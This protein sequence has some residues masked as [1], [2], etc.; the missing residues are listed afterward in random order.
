MSLKVVKLKKTDYSDLEQFL[1]RLQLVD[2]TNAFPE[3]VY[4]STADIRKFRAA[5]TKQGRKQGLSGR[6]LEFAV[7]AEMLN[8]SP[9]GILQDALKPG[10]AVVERYD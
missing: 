10:F 2:G 6:Q 4:V 5:L 9:N 3:R 8:L 7:G 1:R